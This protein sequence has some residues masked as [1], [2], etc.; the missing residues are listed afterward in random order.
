MS[1]KLAKPIPLWI[2]G[3]VLALVCLVQLL[4]DAFP[5]LPVAHRLEA[6]T[7]DWRVRLAERA[8]P[9]VA[10]NLGFVFVDDDSVKALLRGRDFPF[11]FGP[12]WPRQVYGFLVRELAAQGAEA[13][14]FDVLFLEARPDHPPCRLAGG[15]S[16]GSDEFFAREIRSSGRVILAAEKSLPPWE[17]FATNAWAVADITAGRDDDGVLRRVEAYH[18]LYYWH[19]LIRQAAEALDWD[20]EQ[21]RIL[22]GALE[23][24]VSDGSW[25]RVELDARGCFDTTRFRAALEGGAGAGQAAA[26][27]AWAP[28][29]QIK[30]AWQI[31]V[32]L[33]AR[34]LDL[35]LEHADAKPK[36][37]RIILRGPNG[38]ERVIP[39]DADNR[40][41]TD[42]SLRPSDPALTK[43][44]I[45]SLL[46]QDLRR[47]QGDLDGLTN[48]WKGKLVV[49]GS[50]ATGG[51][52]TDLGT[53][54]LEKDAY[55]ISQH[56][57]VANSVLL[58]RFV[59]PSGGAFNLA[60]VFALG[61]LSALITWRV[62]ASASPFYVLALAG[63]YAG[64]AA[65]VYVRWRWW[66][67]VAVPVGGSL[68]MMH[69]SLVTYKAMHEQSER[70]RLKGIFS[71]IVS[72][73]VVNELLRTERLSLDGVQRPVTIL[74]AD[75][76]GFTKYT[77]DTQ[78]QAEEHVR[79]WNL[80]GKAAE[81]HHEIQARQLLQ[82]VNL[83]LTVIARTVKAYEGT[84]DKYIGDCVMAFWGAPAASPTHALSCVKAMIDA[85]RAIHQL[86]EERTRDN[87]RVE[88][89]NVLRLA[90]GEPPL[91]LARV[92]HVGMGINTGVV[93]V[94]L[95]GSEEHGVNYTVFGREVN[96]A[97]RLQGEAGP[98]RIVI[99]E[100]TCAA[101]RRDDP[102]LAARCVAMPV[103]TVK[104]IQQAITIYE[105]PWTP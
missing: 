31:G 67:P 57:N 86:N 84:L 3:G 4:C 15:G 101:L 35:D 103:V 47:Q 40:F 66:I 78:A 104:G 20:L 22:P 61:A 48:R 5:R 93:T 41:L 13:V 50:V 60:V 2:S 62:R 63:G 53:T 70:R 16:M 91:P 24:S 90:R 43:E 58:N 59:R 39:V 77:D 17:L 56:W 105:V 45:Q 82:T 23:F 19:P 11:R 8:S 18:D 80:A 34:R 81:E 30:R 64:A 89:E 9:A 99:S 44:S 88:A 38:M 54:P 26:P 83:Y 97:S 49:V 55:L 14:G 25:Q 74:F 73:D 1:A 36:S 69:A 7:Y 87:A 75:I 27:A 71:K 100:A 12:L 72:P 96:L 76:R 68:L 98:G 102:E 28:A 95:M 32:L 6:M 85:Q 21:V 52:M 94:G 51:N 79:R 65:W 33:A 29:F 37:G 10:T 46:D 92:L 42:W